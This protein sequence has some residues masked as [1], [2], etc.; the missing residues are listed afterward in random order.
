[1]FT[2]ITKSQKDNNDVFESFPDTKIEE[3]ELLRVLLLL[4]IVNIKSYLTL[5]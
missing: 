4:L 3:G 2:I 1:M 5:S